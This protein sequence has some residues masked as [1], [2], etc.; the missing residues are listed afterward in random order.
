MAWN[1]T[2][3]FTYNSEVLWSGKTKVSILETEYFRVERMVL[4][5]FRF[6]A[7]CHYVLTPEWRVPKYDSISY[8]WGGKGTE[9][10]YEH[11]GI[12]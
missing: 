6:D 2:L 1:A 12:W 8:G 4:K 10:G 9:G 5:G 3:Q 7:D 11:G